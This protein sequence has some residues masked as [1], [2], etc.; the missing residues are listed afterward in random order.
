MKTIKVYSECESDLKDLL[1]NLTVLEK[2]YGVVSVGDAIEYLLHPCS[3]SMFTLNHKM[4][5]KYDN[6]ESY[7][8]FIDMNSIKHFTKLAPL[9]MNRKFI[10]GVKFNTYKDPK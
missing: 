9:T 8:T 4:R 6:A 10:Y 5:E 7:L 2:R 3:S 1:N